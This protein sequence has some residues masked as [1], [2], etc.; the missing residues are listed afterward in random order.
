MSKETLKKIQKTLESRSIPFEQFAHEH[1]HTS[2]DAA[3]IRG[4]TLDQAAKAIVIRI[5]NREGNHVFIQG[6]LSGSKKINM[7]VLKK[8]INAKSVSLATPEEVFEV[9]DCTVG[10][11]PPFGPLFGMKTLVDR[12]LLSNEFIYFSAGTHND[13]IKMRSSD[14][15]GLFDFIV[16]DFSF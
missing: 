15:I 8:L 1:V 7:K 5:K 4:N 9:T 10:S 14:F 11:V 3:K 16:E 2:K 12:T 6:V 13:S